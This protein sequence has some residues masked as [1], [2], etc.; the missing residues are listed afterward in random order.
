MKIKL[1]ENKL[2]QIVAESVMTVLKE[3]FYNKRNNKKEKQYEFNREEIN[4][5]VSFLQENPITDIY[6]PINLGYCKVQRI[7][8]NEVS[9]K[10]GLLNNGVRISYGDTDGAIYLQIGRTPNSYWLEENGKTYM[11]WKYEY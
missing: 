1:T 8:A 10:Q 3:A 9:G 11:A 7:P 4:Q 5:L 2:K 6:K